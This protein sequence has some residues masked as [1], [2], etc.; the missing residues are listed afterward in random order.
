MS[1]AVTIPKFT[2]NLPI[3][4]P[5]SSQNNI[6]PINQKN[7]DTGPRFIIASNGLIIQDKNPIEY[8]QQV[9]IIYDP[10]DGLSLILQT[11]PQSYDDYINNIYDAREKIPK[12][13]TRKAITNDNSKLIKDNDRITPSRQWLLNQR[14]GDEVDL[15]S[16]RNPSPP[17][18]F[19]D[20]FSSSLSKDA[21]N[22]VP[23]STKNK[24]YSNDGEEYLRLLEDQ[25][26]EDDEKCRPKYS[27]P[28]QFYKNPS[29]PVKSKNIRSSSIPIIPQ[30]HPSPDIYRGI[31]QIISSPRTLSTKFFENS[32]HQPEGML[33]TMSQV[34]MPES[35]LQMNIPLFLQRNI[36]PNA[37][38]I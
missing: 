37:S 16:E 17:L 2:P 15:I 30:I 32:Y 11:R 5:F 4:T 27:Y 28:K 18:P 21:Y 7:I 9:E 34:G 6:F 26:A 20:E 38:W 23:F 25:L 22:E 29:F 12:E 33:Q 36:G 1:S 24:N 8:K 10:S 3:G 35:L 14:Q 19:R 31:S 13:R